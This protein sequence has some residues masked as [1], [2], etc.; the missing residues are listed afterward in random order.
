MLQWGK[1]QG[2]VKTKTKRKILDTAD[3][4]FVSESL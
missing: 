1:G 2:E 3:K 4:S